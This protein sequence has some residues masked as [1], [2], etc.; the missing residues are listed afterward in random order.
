MK[1]LSGERLWDW[2]AAG[3]Y[4]ALMAQVLWNTSIKPCFY[5]WFIAQLF[6]L[7]WRRAHNHC[8][9]TLSKAPEMQIKKEKNRASLELFSYHYR[10]WGKGQDAWRNFEDPAKF[11]RRTKSLQLVTEMGSLKILYTPPPAPTPCWGALR[12][13]ET[14]L[15]SVAGPLEC[16]SNHCNASLFF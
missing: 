15:E 4:W 1:L 12:P 5:I 13:L 2:L 3:I 11:G 16:H 7:S 6:P 14:L 9:D 8:K 10:H